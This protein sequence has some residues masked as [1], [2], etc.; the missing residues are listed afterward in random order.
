MRGTHF[1]KKAE[2]ITG[3]NTESKQIRGQALTCWRD[4]RLKVGTGQDREGQQV[5]NG[6]LLPRESGGQDWSNTEKK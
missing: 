5:S 1:L 6:H 2:V 4:Q 3:Q